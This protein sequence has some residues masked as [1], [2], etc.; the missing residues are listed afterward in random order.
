MSVLWSKLMGGAM[1]VSCC[2]PELMCPYCGKVTRL[3]NVVSVNELLTAAHHDCP[4][5]W[6]VLEEHLVQH[7]GTI[8]YRRDGVPDPHTCKQPA[9]MRERLLA[10]LRREEGRDVTAQA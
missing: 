7:T 6:D 9:T 2:A 4:D 5:V 1:L 8:G 3:D 10:L